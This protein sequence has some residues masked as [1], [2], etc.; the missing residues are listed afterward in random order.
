MRLAARV[1]QHLE[2]VGRLASPASSLET[3]Q[4]L[5]VAPRPPASGAR[6]PSGRSGARRSCAGAATRAGTAPVR[7][8]GRARAAI[9]LAAIEAADA[10]RRSCA[11]R[12]TPPT[13]LRDEAERA[14]RRA[15]RRGRPRRRASASPPPRRRRPRSSP[16]PTPQAAAAERRGRG[17][18]PA[19]GRAAP[20]RAA[21]SPSAPLRQAEE[22]QRIAEVFATPDA[23]GGRGR[24][25]KQ[26]GRGPR[27][28]REVLADGTEMP[29]TCASSPTR[30]AATPSACCATSGS[31]TRDDRP[32][33]PGDPGQADGVRSPRP[34]HLRAAAELEVPEFLPGG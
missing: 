32:A 9:A 27:A 7:V 28:G 21:S 18:A 22:V 1:R 14:R 10:S 33:R 8:L 13:E 11:R 26:L 23:R 34:S 4:V 31:P 16:R 5:L 3:S 17:R 6:S 30:C 15:H 24:A 12:R 20:S 19:R 25:R 29:A 2:H